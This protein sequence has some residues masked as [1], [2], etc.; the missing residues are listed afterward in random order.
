MVDAHRGFFYRGE[1]EKRRNTLFNDA[2][3]NNIFPA[4][5]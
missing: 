3:K 5:F 4:A 2:I 1:D